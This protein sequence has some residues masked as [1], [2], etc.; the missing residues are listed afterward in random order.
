MDRCSFGVWNLGSW[1]HCWNLTGNGWIGRSRRLL[2]RILQLCEAQSWDLAFS[3]LRVV[4]IGVPGVFC[5]VLWWD[6]C[7]RVL[8]TPS[9]SNPSETP[10]SASTSSCLSMSRTAL[11]VAI[12]LLSPSLVRSKSPWEC[13]VHLHWIVLS[14]VSRLRA[15][16]GDDCDWIHWL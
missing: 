11:W 15:G 5:T 6:L 1:S 13:P 7:P 2:P 9:T 14:R 4:D 16:L 10:H 8:N 3:A 12:M